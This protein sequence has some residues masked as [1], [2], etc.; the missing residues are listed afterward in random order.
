M[1][2]QGGIDGRAVDGDDSYPRQDAGAAPQPAPAAAAPAGGATSAGTYATPPTVP[3][4]L[5]DTT[6]SAQL[7]RA[8]NDSNRDAPDVPQ[9]SAGS[10]KHEQG[11][12]FMWRRDTHILQ[13]TRVGPGSRDGLPTIVGTRPADN[14]SQQV[15]SWFHTHPNEA[16]EGYGT[17]PS[18]GDINWQN[19]EARVPGIIMTHAGIVTNLYP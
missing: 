14:A 8:W 13:I 15:V 5:A 19:A 6:M 17:Q 1:V 11:G 12:W 9:G 10:L 7:Q 2:G 3:T 4:V 18:A 16:S